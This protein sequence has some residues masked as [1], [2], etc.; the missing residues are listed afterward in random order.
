M[1]A[2]TGKNWYVVMTHARSEAIA[3][4]HLRRQGFET[5]LPRIRRVTRHAR[6]TETLS[7]PLF[8]RYVFV[9]FDQTCQRWQAIR[10]TVG[11]TH[12]VGD[13]GGPS[14][15]PARIVEELRGSQDVGGFIPLQPAPFAPGQKLQITGGAFAF[16]SALYEFMSD[17]DRVAVLLDIMGRK[18][19]AFVDRM[20]LAPV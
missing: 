3:A 15:I 16:C 7:S 14:R 9:A 8:P 18:A 13:A 4:E 10:S 1:S 5:Y 2:V 19:R 11:V 6:R 20:M 17:N 12:L